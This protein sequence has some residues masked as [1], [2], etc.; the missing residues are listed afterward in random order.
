MCLG[1]PSL[2]RRMCEA[3]TLSECIS[4][5]QPEDWVQSVLSHHGD[6]CMCVLTSMDLSGGRLPREQVSVDHSFSAKTVQW[7]QM[8]PLNV[9]DTF[10]IE[11]ATAHTSIHSCIL[12]IITRH[13]MHFNVFSLNLIRPHASHTA[14]HHCS[15]VSPVSIHYM[16]YI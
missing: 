11:I 6:V 4:V 3:R 7:I 5:K 1:N 12:I 2:L 8:S 16:K 10:R 15:A 9:T 14:Q 13:V